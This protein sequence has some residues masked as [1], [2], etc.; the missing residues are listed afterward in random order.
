MTLE[1]YIVQ[2][3]IIDAVRSLEI[4]FPLN[5]AV[6]TSSVLFAATILHRSCKWIYSTVDKI[7][8]IRRGG[9]SI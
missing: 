5:W 2:Y 3:V 7:L 6:L 1:I 4:L 9:D 8:V